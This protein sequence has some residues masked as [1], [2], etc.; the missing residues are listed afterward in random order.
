MQYLSHKNSVIIGLVYTNKK[1][2][3]GYQKGLIFLELSLF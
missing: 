1:I 2:Y 3:K